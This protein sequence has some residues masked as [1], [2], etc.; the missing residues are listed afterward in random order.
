M[1]VTCERS[2]HATVH[3]YVLVHAG[4]IQAKGGCQETVKVGTQE[5]GTERGTKIM[6]TK[7]SSHMIKTY[8]FCHTASSYR[9]REFGSSNS[10]SSVQAEQS[11]KS[12]SLSWPSPNQH[13]IIL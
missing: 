3:I 11:A 5:C 10:A 13:T 9:V 2:R 1:V 8:G 7:I 6:H 4:G 12:G